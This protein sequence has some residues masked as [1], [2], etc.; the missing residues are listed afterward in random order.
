MKKNNIVGVIIIVLAILWILHY[1]YKAYLYYFTD[2]LFFTMLPNY[3]L[4]INVILGF[5]MI[6]F[7]LKTI[8]G[9]FKLNKTIVISI[10]AI[11][12][13]AILEITAPL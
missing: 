1:S 8:K 12:L 13:G 11:A 2:L 9:N 7:S 3:V 6:L 5:L 4:V 10:S